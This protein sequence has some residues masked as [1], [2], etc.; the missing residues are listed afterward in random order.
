MDLATLKPMIDW[1]SAN[2]TWAGLAVFVISLSESLAIVGLFVPGVA[3]MFGIGAL[4]ATGALELWATLAWAV[5]GAIV[6]DGLSYWLGYHY[7]DAL[8]ER[9]PF[10]RYPALL[11]RGEGFF[12]RHGGKSVIFGRFVGPVRP[13]IPVVAGMLGMPPGRFL[14]VNV[15]S[16]LAWA[17]A[18]TL[19]GVVFGASL[20][21]ASE[22]AS[23]LAML[24]LTVLLSLWLTV[25]LV[26]R[27]YRL[28]APR[29]SAIMD[30]LLA[31]G[32]EHRYAGKLVSSVLDPEQPEWR[33]LAVL[34]GLLVSLAVGLITA[35]RGLFDSSLIT[36][37]ITVFNFMQGLRAPWADRIMVFL[38]ELSHSPVTLPVT[39]TVMIWL[40]WRHRWIALL[41]VGGATAFALIL[42][43]SLGWSMAV[44]PG[45]APVGTGG[46][47]VINTVLYGLLAV[48]VAHG[49]Q[50]K[51]RWLP[52]GATGLFVA[53]IILAQLYLGITWVSNA[54]IGWLLALLWVVVLG[55]AYRRH[56]AVPVVPRHLT[57]LT[58]TAL[59]VSA[60][61]YMSTHYQ[62]DLVH[63]TPPQTLQTLDT[64]AWWDSD[65]RSLPA[66]RIDLEGHSKQPLSVQWSG[67]L[68][69]LAAQ[70]VSQSWRHPPELNSTALLHWLLPSPSLADLPLLP[71]VHDGRH[72]SLR[73][74]RGTADGQWVVLRLWRS[75]FVLQQPHSPLWVG[76]VTTL[77][78]ARPLPLFT[79]PLTGDE[80]NTP[81]RLLESSLGDMPWRTA[82]RADELNTRWDGTLLLIRAQPT[83]EQP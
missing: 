50:G 61:A 63:H 64:Q 60:T 55:A 30:R 39:A 80:F 44:P 72:D 82:Q 40:A 76:T 41:H 6:G 32:G 48:M 65:W 83:A 34:A 51:W 20:N 69:T 19:P 29:A 59:L 37:D 79:M 13:V 17:P 1:I 66:Y 54:L 56:T 22:V 75:N 12:Q 77:R 38:A 81:L 25:W 78:A 74:V 42:T 53:S 31:W 28:L 43:L 2:P 68:D 11:A 26:Y 10:R 16:A 23:R 5:A 14:L 21:L 15:I 9:W 46:G 24:L 49:M 62:Q 3:V 71:Q 4:I 45:D 58:F 52:Y 47:I 73:L 36:A 8:R 27:I 33:G 7:K 70:L 35:G 18:Y 67:S 57:L